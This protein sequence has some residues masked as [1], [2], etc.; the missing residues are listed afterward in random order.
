MDGLFDYIR[1]EHPFIETVHGTDKI[2]DFVKD[3]TRE[4]ANEEVLEMLHRGGP[5][6]LGPEKLSNLFY[7]K[8]NFEEPLPRYANVLFQRKLL[9]SS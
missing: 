6:F 1:V 7:Y 8:P 9:G 5:Q 4:I 2:R 3:F